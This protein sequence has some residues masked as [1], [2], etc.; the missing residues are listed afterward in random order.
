MANYEFGNDMDNDFDD[1]YH[2][3]RVFIIYPNK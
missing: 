1:T 2:F 3:K